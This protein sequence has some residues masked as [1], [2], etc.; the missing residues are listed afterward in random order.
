MSTNVRIGLII[1]IQLILR[2]RFLWY[3]S[4]NVYKLAA[5]AGT[6]TGLMSHSEQT[7]HM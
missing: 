7:S 5:V 4:Y 6:C 2:L 3:R 1:A